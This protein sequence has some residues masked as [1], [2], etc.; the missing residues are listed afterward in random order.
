MWLDIYKNSVTLIDMKQTKLGFDAFCNAVDALCREQA[1]KIN[2]EVPPRLFS[3]SVVTYSRISL[4]SVYDNGMSVKAAFKQ[5]S[6]PEHI[7]CA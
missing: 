3:A 7:P 4:R 2:S 5:L 6:R 1:A